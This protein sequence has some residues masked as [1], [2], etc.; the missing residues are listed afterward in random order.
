[1]RSRFQFSHTIAYIAKQLL[2]TDLNKVASL[3]QML[4]MIPQLVKT[5]ELAIL[6]DV[7][8]AS[9]DMEIPLRVT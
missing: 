3:T 1:M 7:W 6:E 4:L 5:G 8:V 9:K 2:V